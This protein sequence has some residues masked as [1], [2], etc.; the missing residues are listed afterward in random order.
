[1][2][3]RGSWALAAAL[4]LV[5]A[6]C[7]KKDDGATTAARPKVTILRLALQPWS[8]T[9]DVPAMALPA[10]TVN[11]VAKVPGRVAAV[12]HDEGAWVQAGDVLLELERKDLL[13]ALRTAEGQAAMARAGLA[14]ASVQRDTVARDRGRFAE[15]QKTGSV[16]QA[17][18][19]KVDAG[20][21][22]ADAQ[23]QVAKAQQDVALAG[24]DFARRNLADATVK[25]PVAGL[26]ARR[27]VDVGQETSPAT[28]VPLVI[29]NV[30]DPVH[31]EGAA[32]E[33]VL[34]RL[35]E[36][37]AASVAF[38]GRPGESF[39]GQVT[40]LG[41][42]VDPVSK[43]VRVRVE[44]PNP[45][46]E[47]G[48]RRLIPGMSGSLRVVPQSGK[49]FVLPLNAVRRQDGD[50]MVLLF[51][52]PDDTVTERTVRPLRREGLRFLALDGLAEGMRLAVAAPKEIEVGTKVE[53]AN[54]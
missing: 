27:T 12:V 45:P 43:M 14:A 13:T 3:L 1:M 21:Q 40:R 24:L 6:A 25:A 17:D 30:A 15:L 16:S 48:T 9:L 37:M 46:A 20:F 41:P 52:E 10:A 19:D 39:P 2:T 23:W 49:Y 5:P 31:V 18:W 32:P 8:E 29:L 26:V 28:G 22:A 34:S 33:Y 44:V 11:V 7:A 4:L 50:Q 35:K 53:V 47:D 42:T 36:G 51:V 38:D 54:P